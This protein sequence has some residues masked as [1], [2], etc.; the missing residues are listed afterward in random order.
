MEQYCN[1]HVSMSV[2]LSASISLEP[3]AQNN[4]SSVH[5]A[6]GHD[7]VLM[8]QHCDTLCASGFVN[9]VM[10]SCSKACDS[11][12]LPFHCMH[13]PLLGDDRRQ[14]QLNL[15]RSGCQG[16]VYNAPW[17]LFMIWTSLCNYYVVFVFAD[18][19]IMIIL[20]VLTQVMQF[21]FSALSIM[22]MN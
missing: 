2:C 14:V 8:W 17:R 22:M 11:M 15:S 7:S 20:M 4:K 16:R 18:F 6:C 10:F 1:E 19:T 3:H 13:P 9:I 12:L 5:V 21:M